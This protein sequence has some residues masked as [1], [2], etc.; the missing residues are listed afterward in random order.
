VLAPFQVRS[1][2]FQWPADLAASLSFEAEALILGWYVLGATGS[3]QLLVAFASLQWAG[4]IFSPFFGVIGDRIGLRT[5][6]CATRGIYAFLALLLT[7]LILSETLAVWHAFV[8]YGIAGL[9]RPSDQAMRNVLVSHTMRPELLMGALGISRTTADIAKVA[10]ALLG[11]GGVAAFGMGAA[12]VVVT[13][14]YIGSLAFPRG[15]ARPPPHD[16]R[17]RDVFAH[18]REGARHV[19]AKDDLLGALSIAF[20]VNL[21]AYP[22]MLGLLPYVAREVLHIGQAGLGWLAA[23]FALGGLVGSVT[24][25][26]FR[27]PVR[28][29]RAMLVNSAAW[30]AAITL[31]GL[32]THLGLALALLFVA[33]LVQSLCLLPLAAVMLRGSAPEM[34]G[35]IMGMRVLAIWGLPLGLVASGPIIDAVGF[36]ACALIYCALGLAATFAIGWRWRAALWVG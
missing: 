12:Y 9:M 6:L 29:G 15:G 21:L 7:L 27:A 35:R 32:T 34:R 23:A 24:V 1:F 13:L 31:F 20:L 22:F 3:V 11:A 36:T 18:L 19:W 10:G 33:G 28:A 17:L 2:R 8:I 14:L 25:G 4:S 30:F 16:T 5:L 26:A